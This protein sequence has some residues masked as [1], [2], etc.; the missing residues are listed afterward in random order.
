[1]TQK[2]PAQHQVSK[3]EGEFTGAGGSES[4]ATTTVE[5]ED[6]AETHERG[7]SERM[8]WGTHEGVLP[9]EGWGWKG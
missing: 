3:G 5:G 6:K 7:E 4:H 9:R 1:M 8:A 2:R